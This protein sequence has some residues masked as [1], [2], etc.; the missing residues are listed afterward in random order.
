MARVRR[1]ILL[2][3]L[4]CGGLSVWWGCYLGWSV[5]GGPLDF[6]AIC[7]GSRTLLQHRNPY[8]VSDVE[9][10]YLA[11][12][13]DLKSVSA[14]QY[15]NMT[16]YVN[17]PGTLLFVAPLALLPLAT[18]QILWLML[19]VVSYC[20]AAFLIWDLASANAPVASGFLVCFMLLNCQVVFGG[21]NT[22]GLVVGLCT[23]AAWCFLRGE[24]VPFGVICMAIS[25][26][27][28][29][30]D[31]GLVWLFFVLAGGVYRKRAMQSAVVTA[32]LALIAVL[33]VW[34]VVPTWLHDWR[35]NMAMISSPGGINDPRPEA[36]ISN[37]VNKVISLQ[38]VFSIYSEN[39]RFYNMASYLSCGFLLLVWV[40]ATRR[41]PFSQ[42]RA[43]MALAVIAPLTVLITYHRVHDTKLLIL[44]IPACAML[45]SSRGCIGWIALLLTSAA[46]VVNADIPLAIIE[47]F[48]GRLH[49]TST[50]LP[51]KLATVLIA[52]PNQ[53]VLL[54]M[55]LFYLWVYLREMWSQSCRSILD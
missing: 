51:A 47:A 37:S 7:Y 41:K 48:I 8:K 18:G 55:S 33:W 26:L 32:M 25:L 54:A 49:L 45:W 2:W 1:T 4:V 46:I 21:G 31:A 52:R 22:A 43:W 38:A 10:I 11:E 20:L 24:F 34:S 6:Q 23:I 36:L 12:G 16:L 27:V 15:Q 13:L 39:P 3:V 5:P 29:P 9:R 44:A 53:E 19:G 14:V 50:T 35:S 30:H 42:S 40:I 17:T 28:K